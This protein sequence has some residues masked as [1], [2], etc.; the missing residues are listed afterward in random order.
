MWSVVFCL[1]L[2]LLKQNKQTRPLPIHFFFSST[3]MLYMT[4]LVYMITR[5]TVLMAGSF[6]AVI[7]VEL[8]CAIG[9]SPISS[10]IDTAVRQA[11]GMDG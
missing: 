5:P 1:F 9:K 7:A 8:L 6:L 11:S 10:L 2:L 3:K 4:L